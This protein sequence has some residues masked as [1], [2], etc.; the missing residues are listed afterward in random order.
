MT[1]KVYSYFLLSNHLS[2][3]VCFFHKIIN[4]LKTALSKR[5]SPALIKMSIYV[6][7]PLGQVGLGVFSQKPL[8][9]CT[10]STTRVTGWGAGRHGAFPMLPN[11]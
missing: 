4:F 2:Y 8:Q 10:I 5:L 3:Q 1:L 9:F 6:F 7:H 11:L